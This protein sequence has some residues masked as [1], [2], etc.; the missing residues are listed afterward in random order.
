MNNSLK[1]WWESNPEAHRRADELLKMNHH[2]TEDLPEPYKIRFVIPIII[3]IVIILLVYCLMMYGC[4]K[5]SVT[6]PSSTSVEYKK[7]FCPPTC[8][9]GITS[10]K[11]YT[12]GTI[13]I[14]FQVLTDDYNGDKYIDGTATFSSGTTI[15][16]DGDISV[17]YGGWCE[18]NGCRSPTFCPPTCPFKT[19]A[20]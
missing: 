1:N 16:I 7:T 13:T 6:P 3:T 20:N 8:P 10:R 5:Q 19:S 15:S 12:D 14:S 2:D 4:T 9:C 11:D 17:P 18:V